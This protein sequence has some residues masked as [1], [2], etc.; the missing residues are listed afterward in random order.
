MINRRVFSK[1]KLNKLSIS[2][3]C[4]YLGTKARVEKTELTLCVR[5]SY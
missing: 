2:L 5:G 3:M 4:T 1:I